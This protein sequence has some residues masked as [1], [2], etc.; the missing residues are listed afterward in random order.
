MSYAVIPGSDPVITDRANK[1]EGGE[2]MK[3]AEG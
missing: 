2:Y 3:I 1:D